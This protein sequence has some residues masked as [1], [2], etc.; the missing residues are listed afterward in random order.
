M[1]IPIEKSIGRTLLHT[2]D[3]QLTK[4]IDSSPKKQHHL[5]ESKSRVMKHTYLFLF[6]LLTLFSA[7]SLFEDDD[8]NGTET[9]GFFEDVTSITVDLYIDEVTW[10]FVDK[11]NM[12][13]LGTGTG[14]YKLLFTTADEKS[15][16]IDETWYK[17]TFDRTIFGDHITGYMDIWTGITG[18]GIRSVNVEAERVKQ[19]SSTESY[20]MK[21]TDI[22]LVKTEDSGSSKVYTFE[23]RGSDVCNTGIV[24][25][26]YELVTNIQIKRPEST[27]PPMNAFACTS[28][29]SRIVITITKGS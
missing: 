8:G 7:C 22:P 19:S 26:E 14:A 28:N 20:S 10:V 17:S 23:L 3:F 12:G 6:A 5:K 9:T 24:S 16:S 4:I 29:D 18:D 11:S 1:I 13:Q 27:V 21:T 2:S 25:T 15:V